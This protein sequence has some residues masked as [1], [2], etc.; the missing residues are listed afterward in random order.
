[1]PQ[2][3]AQT[4]AP[5]PAPSNTATKPVPTHAELTAP[6]ATGKADIWRVVAYTYHREA[7]AR[8]KAE[9][10]N[11]KHPELKA[12]AFSPGAS[13]PYLVVLGGSMTRDEAAKMRQTARAK[14][15]PWDTYIQNY[16]H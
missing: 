12:E 6:A 15:M 11:S 7:D 13:K 1:M 5:P 4:V 3:P 10:I 14:G 8:K 2:Q 9:L 16:N